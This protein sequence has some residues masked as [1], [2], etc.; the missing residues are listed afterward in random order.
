MTD[1]FPELESLNSN[2]IFVERA[3]VFK[4]GR[5]FFIGIEKVIFRKGRQEMERALQNQL[6][7]DVVY[8]F[9]IEK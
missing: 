8:L 9:T 4:D 3:R 1:Q 5:F 2:E 7:A 6:K